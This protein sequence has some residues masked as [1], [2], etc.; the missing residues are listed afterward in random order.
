MQQYTRNGINWEPK[1]Q[2]MEE[3]AKAQI[4]D[5]SASPQM[6]GKRYGYWIGYPRQMTP[7][8]LDESFHAFKLNK[9][10]NHSMEMEE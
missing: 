4:E 2:T 7:N 8:V 9:S 10:R 1:G 5:K 3:I 6:K